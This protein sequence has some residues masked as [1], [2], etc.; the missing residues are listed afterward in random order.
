MIESLT[1]DELEALRT[2][3]KTYKEAG[4]LPMTFGRDV[5]YNHPNSLPIVLHEE[6]FHIHLTNENELWHEKT[7]QFYRTSEIHLV[8][9]QGS[10]QTNCYLLMAILSPDAHAQ[11]RDNSVMHSL[12]KM[13]EKFHQQY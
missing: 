5:S 13:A 1:A 12:G 4:V 11:A 9:C 7:L 8:Y 2:D 10:T 6:L 3:F